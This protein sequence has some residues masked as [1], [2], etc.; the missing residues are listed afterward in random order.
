MSITDIEYE[1][2]LIDEIKTL[3]LELEKKDSEIANLKGIVNE[4]RKKNVDEFLGWA[5]QK[6]I[7]D[8]E[9]LENKIRELTKISNK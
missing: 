2:N 3:R 9:R 7:D 6:W 4:Y 1:K 8:V 5:L